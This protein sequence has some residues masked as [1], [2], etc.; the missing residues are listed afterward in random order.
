M[1]FVYYAF[2]IRFVFRRWVRIFRG[3][4]TLYFDFS[5]RRT[6]LF[7]WWLL[8]WDAFLFTWSSIITN[9]FWVQPSTK[10]L[11]LRLILFILYW[12]FNSF[13]FLKVSGAYSLVS[14]F[15]FL[16]SILCLRS[17]AFQLRLSTPIATI[18]GICW[19]IRI[20]IKAN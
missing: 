19:N 6:K 15:F 8:P 2:L 20:G 18:I 14:G 16:G 17:H 10:T 7:I 5:M 4:G 12:C 3:R 1:T 11:S 13:S 9:Y